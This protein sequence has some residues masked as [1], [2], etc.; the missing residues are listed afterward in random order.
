MNVS[1]YRPNLRPNCCNSSLNWSIQ[2]H[3]KNHHISWG[4][5]LW[6]CRT[7]CIII[8]Q[9]TQD[10][11]KPALPRDGLTLQVSLRHVV[12]RRHCK[13]FVVPQFCFCW[14]ATDLR[15]PLQNPNLT[16]RHPHPFFSP[17]SLSPLLYISCQSGWH[18]APSFLNFAISSIAQ[19]APTQP[20]WPVLC[21][22]CSSFQTPS[23]HH[24][25]AWSLL[26]SYYDL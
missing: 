21:R 3:P 20:L 10:W 6:Y 22:W 26:G 5:C 7:S 13:C 16:M 14:E 1:E 11:Q 19:P 23:W 2:S 24:C 9:G 12:S 8:H 25:L 4:G 17:L 18:Q 15:H